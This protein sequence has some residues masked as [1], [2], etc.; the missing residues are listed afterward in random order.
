MVGIDIGAAQ[1]VAAVCQECKGEA[2]RSALRISPRRAGFAELDGWM[3]RPTRVRVPLHTRPQAARRRRRRS[4]AACRLRRLLAPAPARWAVRCSPQG[5]L[6]DH[7]IIAA[8]R[9]GWSRSLLDI[10]ADVVIEGGECGLRS[11]ILGLSALEPAEVDVRSYEAP[12]GVGYLVATIS[13]PHAHPRQ[14]RSLC[15]EVPRAMMGRS[16]GEV[17]VEAHLRRGRGG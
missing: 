3:A 4:R 1:H 2:E 9:T 16:E 8:L 13:S 14:R 6:L 11:F 15:G 7:A 10:D 17:V 12:Y 5:P